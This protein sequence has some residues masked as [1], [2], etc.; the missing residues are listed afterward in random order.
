MT[1]ELAE[2]IAFVR[3]VAD[4]LRMKVLT[5]SLE[6]LTAGERELLAKAIASAGEASN[7]LAVL[8]ASV[9]GRRER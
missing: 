2:R 1:R 3:V 9:W 8:E 5:L 7:A 4:D 6:E